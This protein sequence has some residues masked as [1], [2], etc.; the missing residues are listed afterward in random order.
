MHVLCC[1]CLLTRH[2]SKRCNC[3]LGSS[4]LGIVVVLGVPSCALLTRSRQLSAS[5]TVSVSVTKQL[6][7]RLLTHHLLL[8][9][10]AWRRYRERSGERVQNCILGIFETFATSKLRGSSWSKTGARF[11]SRHTEDFPEAVGPARTSSGSSSGG[12][13]AVQEVGAGSCGI[14]FCLG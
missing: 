13:F 11:G 5:G 12:W 7:K 4:L 10:R 8:V 3:S 6:H 14:G 9:W 2:V 1:G